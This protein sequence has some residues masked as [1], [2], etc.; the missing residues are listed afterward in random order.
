VLALLESTHDAPQAGAL[1]RY[2]RTVA[3]SVG[4]K[5]FVE[6]MDEGLGEGWD[7]GTL[8]LQIEEPVRQVYDTNTGQ[9]KTGGWHICFHTFLT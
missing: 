3:L 8:Q 7:K 4:D 1:A 9:I 5:K 6:Q 2:A